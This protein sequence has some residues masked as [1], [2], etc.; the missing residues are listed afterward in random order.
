MNRLQLCDVIS[1]KQ[2]PSATPSDCSFRQFVGEKSKP[3]SVF[4]PLHFEKNYSYPLIVWL[5][6]DS[7]DQSQ[8]KRV[9]PHISMRNFIGVAP[10]ST[11]PVAGPKGDTNYVGCTWRQEKSS[12]FGA[13]EQIEYC[14]RRVQN[15]FK[16][17]R[18]RVFLAG[19][20]AGATMALRIGLLFPELF[21]GV[22][23][24]GGG[25]PQT[26]TPF[27]N[28]NQ[29]R[30]LP[31]FLSHGRDSE[32]HSPM[33]ACRDIR[34]LHAAGMSLTVRQYPC[35]QELTTQMLGDVNAWMMEIVTGQHMR[36][37][38]V[39]SYLPADGAN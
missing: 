35:H 19:Y 4:V 2:T 10:C 7:D 9:M 39:D 17:H 12:V 14:I 31:L 24:L 29:F 36:R 30:G 3:C 13:V 22:C 20:D 27:V 6:S 18:E 32:V 34:L 25:L 26:L 5:H 16:I 8:L 23:A 11:T 1:V 37:D 33:N 28:I 15:R 38:V 21:A